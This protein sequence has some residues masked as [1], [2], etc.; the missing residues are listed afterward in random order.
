MFVA[1]TSTGV[2]AALGNSL[3]SLGREEALKTE[4]GRFLL[5]PEPD[6]ERYLKQMKSRGQEPDPAKLK[7]F[8]TEIERYKSQLKSEK[9]ST[10]VTPK[11][12]QS[13]PEVQRPEVPITKGQPQSFNSDDLSSKI[14]KEISKLIKSMTPSHSDIAP[15][16]KSDV[17][18]KVASD[19]PLLLLNLGG[20]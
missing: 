4:S 12:E 15:P 17:M 19:T 20:M 9:P 18:P 16:R 13:K 11:I 1:F 6:K 3:G 14:G 10:P 2:A 8:D 7:Q 5:N